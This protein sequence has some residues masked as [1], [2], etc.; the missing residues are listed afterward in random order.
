MKQPAKYSEIRDSIKTGDKILWKG[1][2]RIS[3][4]IRWFSKDF[5]HA[6]FVVRLD[7]YQGLRGRVFLVNATLKSGVTFQ[8]LS[9]RLVEEHGQAYLF[10][11]SGITERQRETCHTLAILAAAEGYE[12]D[13]WGV[14]KNIFGRV[15]VDAE[16]FFCTEVGWWLWKEGGF[17]S[18]EIAPRPGDIPEWIDGELTPILGI[19]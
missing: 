18:G 16:K 14:L 2:G 7:Q 8:L 6:S 5:S 15:F 4:L 3:R 17:V 1:T 19:S 11:P 9:E 12:Y 13:S 10:Q